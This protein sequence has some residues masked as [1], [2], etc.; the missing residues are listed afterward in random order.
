M[1]AL[2]EEGHGL[3]QYTHVGHTAEGTEIT[4]FGLS[5]VK[6]VDDLVHTWVDTVVRFRR[7]QGSPE[8]IPY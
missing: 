3:I 1:T 6:F 7:E 5:T 2:R 8:L 4:F